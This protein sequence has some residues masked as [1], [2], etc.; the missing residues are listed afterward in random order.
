MSKV[1]DQLDER[2]TLLSQRVAIWQEVLTF[3]SL[4]EESTRPEVLLAERVI[5]KTKTEI[6]ELE[7]AQKTL[8]Q[9]ATREIERLRAELAYYENDAQL[10]Q[11]RLGDS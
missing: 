4:T 10:Q 6:G 5:A 3:I 2:V 7:N 8:N 11:Q 1:I 9:E